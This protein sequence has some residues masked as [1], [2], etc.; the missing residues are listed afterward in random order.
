MISVLNCFDVFHKHIKKI[1]DKDQLLPF[2]E[3]I[4]QGIEID[5]IQNDQLKSHVIH[6]DCNGSLMLCKEFKYAHY[7][8]IPFNNLESILNRDY[9]TLFNTTNNETFCKLRFNTSISAE[10]FSRKYNELVNNFNKY[11]KI[12]NVKK[13]YMQLE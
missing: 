6:I 11:K 9:V 8:I 4:V 2:I 5:I 12:P 7:K 10:I 1:K 3:L 13:D